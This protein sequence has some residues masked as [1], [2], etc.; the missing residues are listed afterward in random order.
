GEF[1]LS[2][3]PPGLTAEAAFD[4][5]ML[6]PVAGEESVYLRLDVSHPRGGSWTTFT[7]ISGDN[8]QAGSWLDG[9]GD[10]VDVPCVAEACA[11]GWACHNDWPQPT[12]R[13]TEPM[14]T[15][16]AVPEP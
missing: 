14:P 10:A 8:L 13:P 15:F 6:V 1:A 5:E 2:A 4:E 11:P 12:G 3:L 16:T 7:P 9:Y